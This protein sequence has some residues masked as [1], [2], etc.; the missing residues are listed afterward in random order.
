[1]RQKCIAN[2]ASLYRGAACPQRGPAPLSDVACAPGDE[3]KKEES[4]NSSSATFLR[5]FCGDDRASF[6]PTIQGD[7]ACRASSIW[8]SIP[9]G[10]VDRSRPVVLRTSAPSLERD[11]FFGQIQVRCFSIT[12]TTALVCS[13]KNRADGATVDA[14]G[15]HSK[16]KMVAVVLSSSSQTAPRRN[17][18]DAEEAPQQDDRESCVGRPRERLESS[19]VDSFYWVGGTEKQNTSSTRQLLRDS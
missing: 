11:A 13:M 5:F 19:A 3:R 18:Q 6:F 14:I 7:V 12:A 10:L 1:M 2:E 16:R 17:Q 9:A 15:R 4:Q 8:T